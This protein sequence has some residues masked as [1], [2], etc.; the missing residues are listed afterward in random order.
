MQATRNF[1]NFPVLRN[2]LEDE[3]NALLQVTEIRADSNF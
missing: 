3:R 2:V 1:W